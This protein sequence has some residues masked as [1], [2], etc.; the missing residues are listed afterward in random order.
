MSK[1]FVQLLLSVLVGV[2]A[3]VG[4][5][6]NAVKVRQE[7]KASLRETV[8]IALQSVGNL[9]TQVKTNTSVSAQTQVKAPIKSNAKADTKVKGSLDAQVITGGNVLNDLNLSP[10]ASLGGSLTTNAQTTAGT[11]A[12]GVEV[13]LKNTLKSVLDLNLE[14]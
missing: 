11:N 9:T 8:N 1:F 4:F 3:A 10:E 7:A 12:Q 14:P 5:S 2:S 6:P 13:N